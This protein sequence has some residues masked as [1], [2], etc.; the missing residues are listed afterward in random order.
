M[1][2]C[3]LCYCK[4]PE[5]EREYRDWEQT[6]KREWY[7]VFHVM[8]DFLFLERMSIVLQNLYDQLLYMLCDRVFRGVYYILL[9]RNL[10]LH[11][12]H[13]TAVLC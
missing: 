4:P 3:F 13:D 11:D 8:V 6:G 10:N 9:I 2:L 12:L 5:R 7:F 1:N